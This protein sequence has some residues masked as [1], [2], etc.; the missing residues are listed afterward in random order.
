V[1]RDG[2]PVGVTA[3]VE[4]LE[5]LE[6]EEEPEDDKAQRTMLDSITRTVESLNRSFVDN[7]S[8]VLAEKDKVI[9]QMV[10]ERDRAAAERERAA[11]ERDK[12][13]A[14]ILCNRQAAPL[15]E[16]RE[17][18]ETIRDE[19]ARPAPA[20]VS[21]ESPTIAG[22]PSEPPEWLAPIITHVAPVVGMGM[23]AYLCK[24]IIGMSQDD[25]RSAFAGPLAAAS[26]APQQPPVSPAPPP[27]APPVSPVPP[28]SDLPAE[29]IPVFAELTT[30]EVRAAHEYWRQANPAQQGLVL[31][32]VRASTPAKVAN[33]F[34]AEL[35]RRAAVTTKSGA[36]GAP[37]SNGA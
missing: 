15:D 30:D 21:A 13:L 18:R 26:A 10:A 6:D 23:Q 29:L 14:Q 3:Y 9:A 34:R 4:L 17:L 25:L 22:P 2:N 27:P 11:A 16:M 7:L 28:A 8:R 5:N 1:D 32:N 37:A 19:I 12:I 24:N 20:P 35:R 36:D 31:A 33:M